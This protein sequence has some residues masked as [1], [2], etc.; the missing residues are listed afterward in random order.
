[1][2][3]AKLY[4]YLWRANAVIIFIAGLLLLVMLLFVIWEMISSITV[5]G[6]R[7]SNVNI[8]TSG[9]AKHARTLGHAQPVPGYPLLMVPIYWNQEHKQSYFGKSTRAERNRLFLRT[10]DLSY[11]LLFPTYDFIIVSV[12]TFG[13]AS[14]SNDCTRDSYSNDSEGILDKVK[15]IYR[16]SEHQRTIGLLFETI[17]SDTNR[18]GRLTPAD[19]RSLYHSGPDG[20]N[21]KEIISDTEQVLQTVQLDR[22]TV[23]LIYEKNGASIAARLNIETGT[24]E[25]STDIST[26]ITGESGT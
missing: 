8:K 15:N 16:G 13:A 25:E 4:R 24:V 6:H 9:Q 20:L 26:E 10:D 18:D 23:L 21:P 5:P 14:E 12:K 19:N 11:H 17:T 7:L 2:T 22:K 3:S 1:M